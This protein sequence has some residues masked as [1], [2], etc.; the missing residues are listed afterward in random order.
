MSTELE[1]VSEE[2]ECEV[3]IAQCLEAFKANPEKLAYQLA[4]EEP[5]FATKLLDEL[6]Y[7]RN[8]KRI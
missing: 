5:E 6:L 1:L 4:Y 7:Y 2:I 8:M 3:D